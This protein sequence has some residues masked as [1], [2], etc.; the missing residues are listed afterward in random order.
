[1]YDL[2]K[3]FKYSDCTYRIRNFIMNNTRFGFY[4]IIRENLQLNTYRF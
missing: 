4:T 1:M 2:L 3:V